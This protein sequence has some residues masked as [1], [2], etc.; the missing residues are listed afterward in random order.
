MEEGEVLQ[1]AMGDYFSA[2]SS[3]MIGTTTRQ[4]VRDVC[5]R[6]FEVEMVISVSQSD[7]SPMFSAILRAVK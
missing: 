4:K 5:G 3:D 6:I 1:N 2:G 7:Q